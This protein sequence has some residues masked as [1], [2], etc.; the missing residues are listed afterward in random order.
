MMMNLPCLRGSC[1]NFLRPIYH[2][3]SACQAPRRGRAPRKKPMSTTALVF[4]FDC[5]WPAFTCRGTDLLS[6]RYTT[7][8]YCWSFADAVRSGLHHLRV[9]VPEPCPV[10]D[11]SHQLLDRVLDCNACIFVFYAA[12][13]AWAD[14]GCLISFNSFCESYVVPVFRMV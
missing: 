8:A 4:M 12:I 5:Y 11:A 1:P 2:T 13:A 9:S 3:L 6:G 14:T 10:S 7:M